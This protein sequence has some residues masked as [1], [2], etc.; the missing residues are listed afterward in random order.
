MMTYGTK[1][2]PTIASKFQY[3]SEMCKKKHTS[4]IF[5]GQIRK[6]PNVAEADA[7]T[8][9]SDEEVHATLPV[10]S[11]LVLVLAEVLSKVHCN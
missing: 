6:T 7:K 10:S 8:K 5:V 9:T 11:H 3:N 2:A 1:N 4:S